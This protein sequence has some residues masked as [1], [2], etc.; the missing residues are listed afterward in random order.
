MRV[1]AIRKKLVP[2]LAVAAAAATLLTTQTNA[3]GADSPKS[4]AA[5]IPSGTQANINAALTGTGAK[6]VLCAGSVFTIDSPVTF[7]APNQ[8]LETEGLPT[9]GTRANLRLHGS[10]TTAVSGNGQ[11]GVV[12]QNIQ[13]DGLFPSLPR[14]SGGAL[15]EMGNKGL[16][17]TVQ[18][19]YAHNT[20][21]WSILHFT[22][23]VVAN[24]SAQCTGAKILNNQLGP[25]GLAQKNMWSDGISLSCA[26]S[27][28]QGNTITDATDGGIVLFGATGSTVQNNTIVA[29]TQ[30]LLGGINLVDYKPINGNYNGVVVQ[31][32]TIDAQGKMV[33]VGIAM[34]PAIWSCAQDTV[35]G[36][37]VV[38]NTIQGGH[39]G[40]GFAVN[41]VKD[42]TVTGNVD[43]STHVGTPVAGCGGLPAKPSGFQVAK[44]T[45]STL[46]SQFVNTSAL[47]YLLGITG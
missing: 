32:N 1:F 5:C 13:A 47:T 36:A 18:N 37:K 4:A 26:K 22:E 20:R 3:F 14:A 41:G 19:V 28:V 12:V 24:N 16:N 23:G 33:K 6:A 10:A 39:M 21:T 11:S 42:F 35:Y 31:N 25:G 17:Q 43:K 30:D 27:L 2:A 40:Y 44:Q 9:G 8:V 38:N 29:K 45:A 7:T 46:Q 34:G 15:L